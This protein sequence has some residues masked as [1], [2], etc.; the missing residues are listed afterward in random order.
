M[1]GLDT[2]GLIDGA[3]RGFEFVDRY[4]DKEEDRARRDKMDAKE[5]ERYQKRLENDARDH[6]LRLRQVE[7]SE[8]NAD[9]SYELNKTH[10]D[11]SYG[12]SLGAQ[13]NAENHRAWQRGRQAEQDKLDAEERQRQKDMEFMRQAN[14]DVANGIEPTKEQ[15]ALFG[16]YPM[17][18]PLRYADPSLRQALDYVEREGANIASDD[19]L[20]SFANNPN[21]LKAAS[22]ALR[23]Q[24]DK[25]NDG[26]KREI[27]QII[28][29]EH[30]GKR[31]LSIGMTVTGKDGKPY[32]A[33]VTNKRSSDP[34]DTV[35]LI[36]VE[37]FIGSFQDM[38]AM[39]N[40]TGMMSPES[41]KKLE[42]ANVQRGLS[43]APD[44]GEWK[45]AGDGTIFNNKDGSSK[46]VGGPGGGK[47]TESNRKYQ[48]ML[49]LGTPE[50]VARGVAY[51]TLKTVSD[52][53]TGS[54]SVI[55]LTTNQAIGGF[56]STDISDPDAPIVWQGAT[57]EPKPSER[58]DVSTMS[59]DEKLNAILKA[60]PSWDEN[61]A[62]QF[63]IYKGYGS[64]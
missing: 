63:M 47:Q 35:K 52:P 27:S 38:V 4:Y 13:K 18:N 26:L 8:K 45:S 3:M 50:S 37:Q 32:N 61:K 10:A 1:A 46:Q 25:P 41:L 36:P 54:T 21:T 59:N 5:E 14:I 62:R 20:I 2:R 48:E 22:V 60:N 58:L 6:G 53:N 43:A 28:P 17:Y 31:Y 11:R 34:D 23:E 39:K 7:S 9:R 42:A 15:K 33:P 29:V 44:R 51:G 64:E 12:L 19:D 49:S 55:D 30:N 56:V 24:L 16:K 57:P 40:V